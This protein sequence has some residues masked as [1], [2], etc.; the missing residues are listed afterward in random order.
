[1]KP[2]TILEYITKIPPL[3][4]HFKGTSLHVNEIGDGN[5]NFVFRVSDDANRSLIFK[6]AP[7]YLR[8]LGEDF[9]LPQERICVEMHTMGYFESIAPSFVPKLF[10]CD[11]EAFCFVMED[12]RAY[13]LLQRVRLEEEIS[14]H[15]Y[16]KLGHF[17]ALLYT[18]KPSLHGEDFYENATLKTISENYIFRFPHI[19][20]HEALSVPPFFIPRPKSALFL[21]NMSTLTSLFLNEKE[22]LIHGDLH[23]GSILIHE[24]SVKIIDAEFSCFA[25]LGFDMGVLLAHMLFGELHAIMLEK[26][27]QT[28]SALETL[29]EHFT[30]HV[31]DV[32]PHILSQSVGFCGVELY[33]RL[34]VPA[35][36]K[37]LLSLPKQLQ[38]KAYERVEALAIAF[39][40]HYLHVKQLPDMLRLLK[41]HA[42]L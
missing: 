27:S 12:L 16:A 36:V 42:W 13:R 11:E 40:E 34:V 3:A 28:Q 17:L 35:Q 7:P 39:V 33:R 4:D 14:L 37:P 32:P 26:K 21:A 29:W 20:N 15:V 38:P 18:H 31:N 5:L 25:T 41:E 8:L 1:M 10:H 24:E 2:D 30:H 23:T 22:C 9:K 6:Y 19:A